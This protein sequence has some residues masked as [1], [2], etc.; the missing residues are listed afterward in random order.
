MGDSTVNL[1]KLKNRGALACLAAMPLVLCATAAQG[2][3]VRSQLAANESLPQA[4]DALVRELARQKLAAFGIAEDRALPAI[5]AALA[6]GLAEALANARRNAGGGGG[7]SSFL[8]DPGV[9]DA[10][11]AA[12]ARALNRQAAPGPAGHP[13]GT[14]MVPDGGM[15]HAFAGKVVG[16]NV[17]GLLLWL[18]PVVL[19]V[20]VALAAGGTA[21]SLVGV[22]AVVGLVLVLFVDPSI[23]F[24]SG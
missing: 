15:T 7:A 4:R 6:S 2:R 5:D 21:G 3:Y 22:A 20:A 17:P 16:F 10:A 14:W 9:R 1:V 19:V 12:F 24:G 23:L 8:E 11:A 13:D 18:L